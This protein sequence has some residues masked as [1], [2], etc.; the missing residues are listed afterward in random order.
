MLTIGQ[1]AA[2]A[3][4]TVR[5]V[6][7]YHQ[8]G[9]LPE[10]ERDD[11]GYRRYDAAA[12]VELIQDPH[13]GRGRRAAVARAR[14]AG[15]R[16]RRVRRGRRGDRPAAAGRDPERSRAPPTDRAARRR[17][18]PRAAAR[19]GG[20]PRPDARARIPAADG[21]RRARRLD[22]DRGTAAG[23]DADLHGLQAGAARGPDDAR[24]LPRRRHRAVRRG[25]P[26]TRACRRWPTAWSRRSS[27]PRT[28]RWRPT[29][30]TR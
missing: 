26:T 30:T 22:P 10:P 12:V 27:T 1:L 19:G 29:P 15:G 4:V 17:R 3:G 23:G 28:T 16:R 9:L 14:A 2:Y 13:A 7:F 24:A 25:R 11:S 20:L 18:Q 8:K 21:R 5:A 6:R